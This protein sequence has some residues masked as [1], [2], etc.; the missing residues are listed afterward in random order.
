MRIMKIF[1]LSSLLLL[2]TTARSRPA[3]SESGDMTLAGPAPAPEFIIDGADW[4]CVDII[5]HA[6][7][8]DDM[9]PLRSCRRIV[10]EIGPV[11]AFAWRG[12][13]FDAGQIAQCNAAAKS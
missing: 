13:A 10:A 9:P 3:A 4:Q 1:A 5:C 11:T 7:W 6:A 8:V 12:K 2:A